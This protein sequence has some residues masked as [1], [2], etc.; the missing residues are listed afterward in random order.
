MQPVRK[1]TLL[2]NLFINTLFNVTHYSRADDCPVLL[3]WSEHFN[4][5]TVHWYIITSRLHHEF[6]KLISYHTL[7][8]SHGCCLRLMV[9]KY[10]HFFFLLI[11][12]SS[13]TFMFSLYLISVSLSLLS[14][15]TLASLHNCFCRWPRICYPAP[16][17]FVVVTSVVVALLLLHSS[18]TGVLLHAQCSK[19]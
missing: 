3:Q 7:C 15:C 18:L 4:E 6:H 9:D 1:P 14:S 2:V 17:F 12:I 5:V 19:V 16:Q 8:G 13:I 11:I 10:C